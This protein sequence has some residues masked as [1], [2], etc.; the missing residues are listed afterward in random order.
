MQGHR[1]PRRAKPSRC[2]D[3]R[4]LHQVFRLRNVT[5][6]TYTD[7]DAKRDFN[8]TLQKDEQLTQQFIELVV[9]LVADLQ[10][11]GQ[12][13]R[14]LARPAPILI[15]ELEYYEAIADQNARANPLELVRDFVA[16]VR[17]P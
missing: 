7:E 9:A 10:R 12:S 11:V 14:H 1:G 6:P 13:A 8:A 5:C 17:S 15:H 2:F 16:W 3:S 4:R